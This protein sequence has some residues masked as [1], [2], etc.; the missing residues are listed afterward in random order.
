VGDITLDLCIYN[1][2]EFCLQLRWSRPHRAVVVTW[3]GQAVVTSLATIIRST[4]RTTWPA[5]TPSTLARLRRRSVLPTAPASVRFPDHLHLRRPGRHRRQSRQFASNSADSV[6]KIR[7]RSVLLTTWSSVAERVSCQLQQQRVL[8]ASSR[9]QGP[10]TAEMVCGSTGSRNRTT[11]SR[12]PGQPTSAVSFH[13]IYALCS[14]HMATPCMGLVA[15]SICVH[16]SI[17]DDG[18]L[19]WV[20]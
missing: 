12:T 2:H 15:Y 9:L 16:I 5:P 6:W 17:V 7:R 11:R 10:S 18:R 13:Y 19:E 8:P 3:A 20:G 4:I 14:C 1:F